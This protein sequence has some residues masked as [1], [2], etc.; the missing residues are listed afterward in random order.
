M[1]F[2]RFF[3]QNKTFSYPICNIPYRLLS[4]HSFPLLSRLKEKYGFIPPSSPFLQNPNHNSTEKP[5]K[6][7][8][9]KPP[10]RPV[11]SLDSSHREPAHS[12]LPFDFRFSYT[13]SNP[14]VRPIGLRGP[15]YSPFGPERLDRVW[16]GLSAPAM[17]PMLKS[18]D[19][20][21]LEGWEGLEKKRKEIRE[22][23]LGE[24][25]SQAEKAHLIDKCQKSKTKRQINLGRSFIFT[26]IQ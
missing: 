24:P 3:R 7:K 21:G 5:V 18:V 8:Q 16:T 20:D 6:K 19:G 22:K 2:H 23:V 17:E 4:S 9:K 11:S 13:E 25:L 14:N 26:L 10:Y 1:L 15:K 12:D